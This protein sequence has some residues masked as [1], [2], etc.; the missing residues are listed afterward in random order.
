MLVLGVLIVVLFGSVCDN[1]TEGIVVFFFGALI[2]IIIPEFIKKR[3][4]KR[5][6]NKSGAGR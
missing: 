2:G 1:W 6:E 4:K 5:K 3:I